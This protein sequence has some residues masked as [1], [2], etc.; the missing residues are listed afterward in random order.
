MSA[1]VG[2]SPWQNRPLAGCS[3][4]SVSIA[5]KPAPNQCWIQVVVAMQNVRRPAH[6]REALQNLTLPRRAGGRRFRGAAQ[7][8]IR[9]RIAGI[10]GAS[11]GLDAAGGLGHART[12][13]RRRPDLTA[14]QSASCF[15][16][17]EITSGLGSLFAGRAMRL[18]DPQRTMRPIPATSHHQLTAI[19][20]PTRSPLWAGAPI[21]PCLT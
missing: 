3:A 19:E 8:R 12:R 16:A 21:Q 9:A 18:G 13:R 2:L 5:C 11:P 17:I 1:T 14:H 7:G 15:A 10:P 6:S 4:S 20:L